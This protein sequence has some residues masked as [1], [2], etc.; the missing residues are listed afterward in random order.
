[1]STEHES[2]PLIRNERRWGGEVIRSAAIAAV[3]VMSLLAPLPAQSPPYQDAWRWV[4][5]NTG[6]GLQSNRVFDLVETPDGTVWVST[7]SGVAWFDGFDWTPADESSGLPPT[8]TVRMVAGGS[9]R[10][11]IVSAG[12]IFAATR[13]GTERVSFAPEGTP[14]AV[15]SVARADENSFVVLDSVGRFWRT[16][17]TFHAFASWRPAPNDVRFCGILNGRPE[18]VW[19]IGADGIYQLVGE[20]F[21]RRLETAMP[22]TEQV[23]LRERQNGEGALYILTPLESHGVWEFGA[24][25]GMKRMPQTLANDVLALDAMPDGG[26]I[27]AYD[28]GIVQIVRNGIASQMNP[29][30]PQLSNL[31]FLSHRPNGDLW[32]GS[33]S[34]LAIFQSR[35]FVW[36]YW[37]FQAPD[38]RNCISALALT[39]DGSVWIGNSSEVE[40][41]LAD[42]HVRV[43]TEAAGIPLR[44]VTGIV[45]DNNSNVWLSSGSAFSGALRWDGRTWRHFTAADGLGAQTIHRIFKDREGRLWFLGVGRFISSKAGF[46]AEPG[47]YVFENGHFTRWGVEE[48]LPNGRVFAMAEGRDGALWFGTV[49]GLGRWKNGRWSYWTRTRGLRSDR[50]FSIAIDADDRVWIG[51]QHDGV[52]VIDSLDRPSYYTTRDGLVS[53]AVWEIRTDQ[54]GK[55][56]IATAAGLSSYEQG[57]W[58]KIDGSTGLAGVR[59][60]PLLP[61]ED[62]IYVGTRGSG[63]AILSLDAAK[64]P[65]PKVVAARPAI[66]NQTALLRW[67]VFPFWGEMPFHN[68]ESRFRLD[69]GLWSSWSLGREQVL[70]DLGPGRHAFQIQAKGLFG[71]FDAGT[72]VAFE[73]PL[74]WYRTPILI[75]S[76]VML[77]IILLLQRN[78]YVRRRRAQE[79]AMIA[80]E[81][82]YRS[83]FEDSPISI[84]E[85]DFTEVLRVV[86][87]LRTRGIEDLRT[88]FGRH[89]AEFQRIARL[90]RVVDVNRATLTLYRASSKHQLMQEMWRLME[91]TPG[92]HVRE[93]ICRIA[94]GSLHYESEVEETTL[95]G[96]TVHAVVRHSVLPTLSDGR[97]RVIVLVV[98]I[99]ER[100]RLEQERER[101]IANLEDALANVKSLR[102]L[103][104][105]CS[106]CKKIRDD[107]GYWNYLEQYLMEHSDVVISHG[108]C[109]DCAQRLYPGVFPRD[110]SVT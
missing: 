36:S 25:G 51:D 5:Y 103:V 73:I 98:D 64:G 100:K 96:E 89:P 16:D 10:I 85:E 45:E 92:S 67:K 109:P 35:R 42:G 84:W 19:A 40:V 41:H 39:H 104:P 65:G 31:L 53:D 34:G 107:R 60:W 57:V 70:V 78:V 4:Q 21:V 17:S 69:D 27:I 87:E 14:L 79:E 86:E 24:S 7:Q 6:S 101:L 8:R 50:V 81:R 1:M 63:T 54:R 3:A 37:K 93:A 90:L 66:E 2:A 108:L 75:G 38:P 74:P 32:A 43:I 13:N 80:S 46:S 58:S 59:L 33:E 72:T 48:G 18:S 77:V 91:S 55:I 20:R 102:G 49:G 12:T 44:T 68:V 94:E 71:A 110:P 15:N 61:A 11:L 76:A 30:P 88:H 62:R 105:I 83:L 52:C 106:S 26:W 82:R 29:L 56:W 22:A 23:I 97:T 28:I 95:T 99:T 9:D 47:A